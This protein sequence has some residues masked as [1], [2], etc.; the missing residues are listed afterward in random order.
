MAKEYVIYTRKWFFNLLGRFLRDMARSF[1]FGVLILISLVFLFGPLLIPG[2][3]SGQ[4]ADLPAVYDSYQGSFEEHADLPGLVLTTA[5]LFVGLLLCVL[6][7]WAA[8]EVADDRH[9]ETPLPTIWDGQEAR[10]IASTISLARYLE[11]HGKKLNTSLVMSDNVYEVAHKLID[12]TEEA[13]LRRYLCIL[14]ATRAFET[15]DSRVVDSTKPALL[16][17]GPQS[18][19]QHGEPDKTRKKSQH[20]NGTHGESPRLKP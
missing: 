2:I 8:L 20:H 7:W 13:T 6:C 4:S 5:S 9:W 10:W 15:I 3:C 11:S 17:Q 14:L 12:Q 1:V 16:P 19:S 18:N